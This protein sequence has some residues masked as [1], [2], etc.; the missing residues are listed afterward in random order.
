MLKDSNK[1]KFKDMYFELTNTAQEAFN[2]LKI[3]FISIPILIHFNLE[4]KI[5]VE[6]DTFSFAILV[7]MLQLNIATGVWHSVVF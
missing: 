4:W 1:K 2:K 7:I 5:K 6:T 3:A